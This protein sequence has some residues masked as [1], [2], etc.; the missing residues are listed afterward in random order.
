MELRYW[1]HVRL[2]DTG[3]YLK[4][5]PPGRAAGQAEIFWADIVR[6]WF[7]A[8]DGLLS[9][10]WYLFTK[11][12]PESYAVPVDADGS[13]ALLAELLKRKL[14]PAELAIR[15]AQ[16]FNELFCWPPLDSEG[17]HS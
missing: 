3:V 12:R 10:A 16:G 2:T 11:H 1:Y 14:F 8:E 6:V 4:V 15:A 5:S 13:E 9:D 7:K 17:A